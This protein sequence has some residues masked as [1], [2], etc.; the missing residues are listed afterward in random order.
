MLLI[1]LLSAAVSFSGCSG[2]TTTTGTYSSTSE[3]TSGSTSGTTSRTAF[4][5]SFSSASVGALISP[6]AANNFPAILPSNLLDF[7]TPKL[8]FGVVALNAGGIGIINGKTVT[9]LAPLLTNDLGS[10]GGGRFDAAIAPDG[11]TALVTNFG[12]STVY[13]INTSV[14]YLPVVR[15]SVDVGFFAEDI[16]IT[17]D[18]RYALV[19]DGGFSPVIAVLDIQTRTIVQTYQSPSGNSFQSVAVAKDG[20]T[21]LCADYFA[22]KVHVLTINPNGHMQYVKSFDVSSGGRPV[23]VVISPD[24]LTAIVANTGGDPTIRIPVLSI[25][26]PGQVEIS[27]WITPNANV[28]GFRINGSQSVAFNK[29]STQAYVSCTEYNEDLLEYRSV[30][31][32]LDIETPGHAAQS[33]RPIEVDLH[34]TSQLFGVDTLAVD[35]ETGYLYFS[36]PTVSGG[37]NYLQVVDV[38]SRSVIR[39]ISFKPAVVN[40]NTP[41]DPIWSEEIEIPTGI[42]FWNPRQ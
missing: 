33:G 22:G 2:D 6:D 24:G 3:S 27:K 35:F 14:P 29:S 40:K 21:V 34:G 5:T 25:F 20:E 36:N 16:D 41:E 10:Y 26:G 4:S 18:G 28:T 11:K 17:P 19:T 15:G 8:N 7:V 38:Q 30:V 13:F 12:D 32:V 37:L 42:A 9:A 1:L 23:N 31:L 39:S